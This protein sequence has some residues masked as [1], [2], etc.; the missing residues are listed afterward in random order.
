[1]QKEVKSLN[2]DQDKRRDDSSRN[3]VRNQQ[4]PPGF[5]SRPPSSPGQGP[6]PSRPP[7]SPGQGP[8][9][10]RPPSAPPNYTPQLPREEE[11]QLQSGPSTFRAPYGGRIIDMRRRPRNFRGCMNRF[12]FIWLTNGNNFWFYPVSIGRNTIEGFRWRRNRWEYD[13]ININRI[14]FHVCS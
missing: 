14:L 10:G 4:I 7:S 5:P 6:G 3:P 9:P 11:E 12:T 2:Y 8:V 13:R 1:M